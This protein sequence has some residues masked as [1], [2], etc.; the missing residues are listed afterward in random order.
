MTFADVE[1]A[2]DGKLPPSARRR[3]EWWSNSA[4]GHSQAQAWM[5]ASYRTSNVNLARETVDFTLIDWPKGY[6]DSPI[7]FPGE[8]APREMGMAETAQAP[9]QPPQTDVPQGAGVP[10]HPLFGVW[11][12]KVTLLPGHDYTK[13]AF[14]PDPAP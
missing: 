9:Y 11:K 12:G 3:A 10:S 7:R 13:P 5:R 1:K 4:R 14:D 6:T 8:D 2:I